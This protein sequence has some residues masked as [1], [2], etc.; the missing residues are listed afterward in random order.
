MKRDNSII[1]NDLSKCW[2]CGTTS[3]LHTHEVF[4]GSANRQKSIKYG[5]YVRLCGYHHNLSNNGVHF[6]KQLDTKLK[7][8]TQK[9]FEETHSHEEFIKVFGKNYL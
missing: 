9:A 3:N 1:Q 2:V 8:E 5:C 6:N 7:Q 4:Y